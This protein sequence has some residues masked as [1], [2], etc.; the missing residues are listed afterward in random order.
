M[1]AHQ[2]QGE[3]VESLEASLEESNARL[4]EHMAASSRKIKELDEKLLAAENLCAKFL[5]SGRYWRQ[6]RSNKQNKLAHAASAA[7]SKI[8]MPMHGGGRKAQNELG[9]AGAMQ[10]SPYAPSSTASSAASSTFSSPQFDRRA[11]MN[12]LNFSSG[13]TGAPMSPPPNINTGGGG[14]TFNSPAGT[15]GSPTSAGGGASQ[16]S[17]RSSFG[18]RAMASLQS[19]ISGKPK[20]PETPKDHMSVFF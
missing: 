4:R 16:Q 3:R 11:S 10:S 19:A 5:E 17:S 1:M 8:A 13:A 9:A 14:S 2:S 6:E 12:S 20:Q 15:L 7:S 18:Q